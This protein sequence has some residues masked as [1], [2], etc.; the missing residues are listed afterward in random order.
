[1][2]PRGQ[3]SRRNVVL[4]ERVPNKSVGRAALPTGAGKTDHGGCRVW[5][6]VG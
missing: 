5:T 1:M 4:R 2:I 6:G 3:R